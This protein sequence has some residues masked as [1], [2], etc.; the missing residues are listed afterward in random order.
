LFSSVILLLKH[1]SA[2]LCSYYSF[3]LRSTL[4]PTHSVS[5]LHIC[6]PFM[7]YNPHIVS[8]SGMP[9]RITSPFF[10]YTLH[11]HFMSCSCVLY[12]LGTSPF[13]VVISLSLFSVTQSRS[14]NPNSI[15]S[16]GYEPGQ[17]SYCCAATHKLVELRLRPKY[18]SYRVWLEGECW[19]SIHTQL[20]RAW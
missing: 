9:P 5:S 8:S 12:I 7:H 20:S 4:L 17:R 13:I 2:S 6:F 10:P 14:N 1:A 19:N 15:L 18:D 16:T 3:S 11:S